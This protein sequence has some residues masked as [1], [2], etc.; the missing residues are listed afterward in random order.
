MAT[1]DWE[2]TDGSNRLRT[3]YLLDSFGRT[4]AVHYGTTTV[5]S[6][7]T[8]HPFYT[9]SVLM[10]YDRAGRLRHRTDAAG[11]V[12]LQYRYDGSLLTETTVAGIGNDTALAAGRHVR[13]TLDSSGRLSVLESTW[14]SLPGGNTLGSATESPSVTY[15]YGTADR[16]SSITS[17]G[18]TGYITRTATTDAFSMSAY[19]SS[20][21]TYNRIL[22][23]SSTG[24]P[25]NH[26]AQMNGIT[27]RNTGFSWDS[28]R[29]LT[30]GETDLT[31]NYGY[32]DKSQVASAHKKFTSGGEVAA[33]TQSV[34]NYDDI[35]NRTTLQEGGTSTL[36][37][38]LRTTTYKGDVSAGSSNGAN[39]LNQYARIER[40]Q[41]FDVTGRRAASNA[42]IIVNGIAL[43]SGDFQPGSG[44]TGLYFRKEAAN[45]PAPYA[46]PDNF[47]PVEVKQNGVTL[48]PDPDPV[49][50]LGMPAPGATLSYDLD[51][52]ILYDGRWTYTWDGENRLLSMSAPSWTQPAAGFLPGNDL[53]ARTITFRYDGFSRRISKKVSVGATLTMEGYLYDGW[54]TVMITKLD[55]LSSTETSQG[56]RWSCLWKP[57]VGSMLYARSPW[58]KA[59]SVGGLA[60]LQTGAQQY[61]GGS[62]GSFWGSYEIHVPMADHL[63]NIRHYAQ[64]KLYAS[65]ET[66]AVSANF[67]YDAYGR[68]VRANGTTVP[69]SNPPPTLTSGTPFADA[70]PFHFSS[71]FTDSE[72]GLVYY[73]YRYYDS[74]DGRWLNRDP[75][76]EEGGLNLYGMV[77]NEAVNK[78]DYLGLAET[79][80][81]SAHKGCK[82]KK[83]DIDKVGKKNSEMAAD[84]TKNFKLPL[85]VFEG[86]GWKPEHPEFG[87]NIC[88]DPNTGKVT[89]TKPGQG[90]FEKQKEPMDGGKFIYEGGQFDPKSGD[91]CPAGTEN[92]GS[93]HSHPDG[94]SFSKMGKNGINGEESSDEKWVTVNEKPLFLGNQAGKQMR[95][96]MQRIFTPGQGYGPRN[97]TISN[98]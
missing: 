44:G 74:I 54:N 26:L 62:P 37:G 9:P 86:E 33:G 55:P 61:F 28:D 14:G 45:T 78:M 72:T 18:M 7:A 79:I 97:F 75:I 12:L 25:S 73:G 81:T 30:R 52:N 89:A 65:G 56:R 96:D 87:G 71:K 3:T 17:G 77:G 1:R 80:D 39:A 22:K 50:Y 91:Q 98:L 42:T 32:D 4:T 60:W 70:L 31:W 20:A 93:Y 8:T 13:R 58:Q 57:D 5:Q 47:E 53:E 82:C 29:L 68:E 49:Q 63:G 15:A 21:S 76:G 35:G 43:T 11:T 24:L 59:G 67:E 27:I 85:D 16:L 94:S 64:F 6:F 90:K 83:E 88:C 34:Y 92:V 40:P 23:S 66:S 19:P 41:T 38:G 2:R 69:A 36:G 95:L 51:G 84:L 48:T 10:D 46:A